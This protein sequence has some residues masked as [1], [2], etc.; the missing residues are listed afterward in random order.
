MIR[1]ESSGA[2]GIPRIVRIGRRGRRSA[3]HAPPPRF[4]LGILEF[5]IGIDLLPLLGVRLDLLIGSSLD[6]GLD[7]FP[8]SPSVEA[9][10]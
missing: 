2:V 9:Q 10:A 1:F 8:L 7:A 4:A 6:D 3:A 5:D